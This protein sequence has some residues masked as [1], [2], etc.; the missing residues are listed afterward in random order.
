MAHLQQTPRP[1]LSHVKNIDVLNR[2][3]YIINARLNTRQPILENMMARLPGEMVKKAVTTGVSLFLANKIAFQTAA[4][5]NKGLKLV[6]NKREKNKE[7]H[8]DSKFYSSL[9]QLGV[10]SSIKVLFNKLLNKKATE[11]I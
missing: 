2:E 8:T 9:T 4:V 1:D 7:E 3:I 10:F 5:I 11:V 6:L